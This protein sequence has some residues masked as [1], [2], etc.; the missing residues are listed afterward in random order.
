MLPDANV[1]LIILCI[2][3]CVY[4]PLAIPMFCRNQCFIPTESR[5]FTSSPISSAS[6][7]PILPLAIRVLVS[8]GK[9]TV[10]TWWKSKYLKPGEILRN[11]F[12]RIDI[13]S[14]VTHC[15]HSIRKFEFHLSHH[16]RRALLVGLSSRNLTPWLTRQRL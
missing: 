8:S 10:S 12:L 5:I 4:G 16:R 11:Q 1:L 3:Q 2:S 14:K 7:R 13:Q 15:V 6:C 9:G